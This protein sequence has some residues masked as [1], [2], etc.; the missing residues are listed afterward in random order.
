MVHEKAQE[1]VGADLDDEAACQAFENGARLWNE[2]QL[3]HRRDVAAKEGSTINGFVDVLLL[4]VIELESWQFAEEQ[5]RVPR[6]VDYE[7]DGQIANHY[8]ADLEVIRSNVRL[9]FLV[10][11][12][13]N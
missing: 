10:V 6:Q 8:L 11:E 13:M 3:L 2:L 4:L 9:P 12:A 7:S 5:E 1:D